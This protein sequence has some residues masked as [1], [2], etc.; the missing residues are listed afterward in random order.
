MP[1]HVLRVNTQKAGS[2]LDAAPCLLAFAPLRETGA[3]VQIYTALPKLHI[4]INKGRKG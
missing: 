3:F 1:R 4:V 2:A